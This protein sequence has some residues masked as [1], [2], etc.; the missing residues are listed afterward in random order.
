MNK[1]TI[2]KILKNTVAVIVMLAL[3][4]I[5]FYQNRDRDIFKFGKQESSSVIQEYT[6]SFG[7]H[8]YASVQIGKI[9]DKIA[10]L[11]T[12]S[13]RILDENAQGTTLA[14]ALSEP[15]MHCEG[16][17]GVCYGKNS[18]EVTVYKADSVC[19]SVTFDHK[20]IRAKVNK[21]GYLFAATEKEGYNCEC[22]VYNRSG[23]AVFRW[24][25]SKNEFL[26]GDINNGNN[27]IAISVAVAG[28]E[29]LMS[30]VMLIDITEAEV[31]TKNTFDSQVLFSLDFNRNDT[32][33]AF[34]D[35]NLVYFN[36]DGTRK[37][38]YDFEGKTLIK[39]DTADVD[40]TVLVF[41]A[42]G[43]G[44]KGNSTD[45][46]VI[47]RLGKVISEKTFDSVAD[48]IS[49]GENTIAIAFGKTVYLTDG[50]LKIK[51][52]LQSDSSIKKI[53]LFDDNKH[54]FI[55]GNSGGKI[56]E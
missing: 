33:T 36:A 24:D 25:I 17:Y 14:Q 6:E 7:A 47:N 44:I 52:E 50:D 55:I 34:G 10:Y 29:N 21:N 13:L 1:E 19:Y 28:E 46:K 43:S 23:E 16:E 31:L 42:A 54:L 56:L 40:M 26:D 15:V 2:L 39:A 20:V 11:T 32:F 38:M 35:K 48:D 37:W 41:S 3:F 49:V 45:V 18:F 53:E 22:I 9:G 12:D 5:I 8:N 27:T 4:I 51:K 30:E